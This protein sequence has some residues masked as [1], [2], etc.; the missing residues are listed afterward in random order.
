DWRDDMR[1]GLR[2]IGERADSLSR[3]MI[4]Y[5]TLARLPAPSR[6]RVDVEALVRKVASLEQRVKVQVQAGEPVTL[7]ADPDQLEQAL[8]N[9]VKNA[10]EASQ[11]GEGRV[12]IRWQAADNDRLRI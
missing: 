5:A 3:F 10:V 8:I 12:S 2:I 6:R 4:G 1:D 11:E 7:Q 9:L